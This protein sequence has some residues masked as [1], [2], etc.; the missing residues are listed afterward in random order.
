[1][2]IR[3]KLHIEQ[4]LQSFSKWSEYDAVHLKYYFIFDDKERGGIITL[5]NKDGRWSI[6][7]KGE[8]YCDHEETLLQIDDVKKL[9]WNHRAAV[10]RAIKAIHGDKQLI[11]S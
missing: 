11:V 6:H 9:I 1:M 3:S 8:S 5:M 4:L 2:S 10:N 7:G